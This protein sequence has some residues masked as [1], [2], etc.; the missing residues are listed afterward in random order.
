MLVEKKPL[1]RD[2]EKS[3]RVREKEAKV[4]EKI[5]E[6]IFCAERFV[7]INER[8]RGEEKKRREREADIENWEGGGEKEGGEEEEEKEEEEE[9]EED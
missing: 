8:K 2:P 1:M 7:G 9:N 3:E 6:D 4:S 5:R